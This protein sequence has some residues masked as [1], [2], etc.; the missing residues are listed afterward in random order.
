MKRSALVDELRAI[1]GDSYLLIKKEDVIVY[2]QDG[3]ILQAMPEIVVVPADAAE[4]SAVVRAAGKAGAPDLPAARCPP[5]AA[6]CSRSRASTAFSKSTW[7]IASRSS[8]P[9]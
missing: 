7:K 8:S 1:V 9:A 3:S 4:V 6:S 2:E 5:K